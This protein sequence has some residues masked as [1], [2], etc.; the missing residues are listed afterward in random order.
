MRKRLSI[1]ISVFLILFIAYGSAI[2]ESVVYYADPTAADQGA[3]GTRTI[4]GLMTAIGSTKQATIVLAHTSNGATTSYTLSTDLTI[5]SNISL[6]IDRGA[7]VAIAT[8]KTLTINGPFEHGEDQAFS[9]TGTGKVAFGG[10][11][12]NLNLAWWGFSSSATAANNTIYFNQAVASMSA[13]DNL[14]MPAGSYAIASNTIFNPPDG[15]SLTCYGIFVHDTVGS[16]VIIGDSTGT[17]PSM[18]Y[19]IKGLAVSATAQDTTLSRNAV[20][21]RNGYYHKIDIKQ[22][23]NHQTGVKL[24][25]DGAGVSYNNIYLNSVWNNKYGVLTHCDNSGWVNYNNF[26]GGQF[27]WSSGQDTAGYKGIYIVHNAT[28]NPNHNVFFSPSFESSASTGANTLIGFHDTGANNALIF[29]RFELDA[30]N[31]P[32]YIDSTAYNSVIMFGYGNTA[33]STGYNAGARTKVFADDDIFLNTTS[34]T[35]TLKL[36]NTGSNGYAVL[37]GLNTAGT[38][39]SY[40]TGAGDF[41]A[42]TGFYVGANKVVGARNTGWVTMGGTILEDCS[43]VNADSVTA[44]DANLRLVARCVKALIDAG[45]THGFIGP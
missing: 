40:I 32:W 23:S 13:G 7:V 16:G 18:F 43:S 34:A 42:T 35:G 36:Q 4:K 24:S 45:I 38:Q 3:A 31:Y 10:N 19:D 39:T 12:T 37:S 11:T 30:N 33:K 5:S 41:H 28:H 14:I 2:A 25:G 15:C 22:A 29:P 27:S 21:I 1:I 8:G 20:V 17:T 9:C 6:R 44:T 26:Y